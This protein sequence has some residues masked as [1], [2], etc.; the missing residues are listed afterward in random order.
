MMFFWAGV[1]QLK[2]KQNYDVE[3]IDRDVLRKRDWRSAVASA[4]Q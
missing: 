3:K 2:P 1:L 4:H